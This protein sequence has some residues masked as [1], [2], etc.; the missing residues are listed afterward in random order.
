MNTSY[1]AI[2][3]DCLGCH[4]GLKLPAAAAGHMTK[5][6]ACGAMSPVPHAQTSQ[7]NDPEEVL[8]DLLSEMFP[9][10]EEDEQDLVP[11]PAAA[12]P[13]SAAPL[14]AAAAPKPA[15][16]PTLLPPAPVARA[17][18]PAPP[19]P[20]ARAT[21]AAPRPGPT[22]GA[23]KRV[24]P[25]IFQSGP[26]TRRPQPFLALHTCS[27]AGVELTFPEAQLADPAF[28]ASMP[29]RCVLTGN[30]PSQTDLSARPMVFINQDE[31]GDR[32]AR[33]VE[34]QFEI[35]ADASY[36]HDDYMRKIGTLD[37]LV[38]PFD[39]PMPYLVSTNLFDASLPC[40]SVRSDSQPGYCRV[41]IPSATTAADWIANVN[42]KVNAVWRYVQQHA[43]RM[44]CEAWVRL[45]HVVRDRINAWF[46][47]DPGE[48]FA[49]YARHADIATKESGLGGLLVTDQRM[50]YH[51][52]RKRAEFPLQRPLKIRV[53]HDTNGVHF[54]AATDGG[55]MKKLGPINAHEVPLVFE[56]LETAAHSLEVETDFNAAA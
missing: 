22:A 6:P 23:S 51:M 42:G 52:F 32:Q 29:N 33:A 35:A 14:T 28:R 17:T 31:H 8:G 1:P 26:P 25:S 53:H 40:T 46:T 20:A 9:E 54:S 41:A 5:C 37:G 47:F 49:A 7:D 44:S 34:T 45:P 10:D 56:A 38:A 21:T 24:V 19:P 36:D 16:T 15:P 11:P 48:S 4:R 43:S 39:L 13:P 12:P 18:A 55:P 27:I 2:F 50:V 30:E 3:V